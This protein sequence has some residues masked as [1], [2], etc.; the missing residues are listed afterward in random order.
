VWENQH[1]LVLLKVH[2]HGVQHDHDPKQETGKYEREWDHEGAMERHQA[3][4][5]S[6]LILRRTC[7]GYMSAESCQAIRLLIFE[8][9]YHFPQ[10]FRTT[11]G[12]GFR[13]SS[14]SGAL[15]TMKVQGESPPFQ[16][17]RH[18]LCLSNPTPPTTTQ[19]GK[20]R[21]FRFDHHEYF[22]TCFS[23]CTPQ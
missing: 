21:L 22:V 18:Q 16:P 17:P 10:S 4:E 9:V 20:G 12:S 23:I 2:R 19:P 3:S 6:V 11:T 8:R 7:I 5:A 13:L 14:P 1:G 15:S